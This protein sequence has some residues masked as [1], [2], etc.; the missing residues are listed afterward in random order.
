[1]DDT[2]AQ[3]QRRGLVPVAPGR[4]AG[5]LADRKPELGEDRA[6]DLCQRQLVDRLAQRRI[7]PWDLFLQYVDPCS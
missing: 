7:I 6:L 3:R 2:V 1:V 4:H 5:I